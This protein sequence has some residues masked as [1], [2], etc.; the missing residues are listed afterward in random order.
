[1]GSEWNQGSNVATFRGS[2]IILGYDPVRGKEEECAQCF[3]VKPGETLRSKRLMWYSNE[4]DVR[5]LETQQK[6]N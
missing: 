3:S 1:M 6:F 4:V 5:L 2:G